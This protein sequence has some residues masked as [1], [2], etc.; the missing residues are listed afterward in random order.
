MV[1]KREI[2]DV[3][4]NAGVLDPATSSRLPYQPWA[5]HQNAT[6]LA[7]FLVTADRMKKGPFKYGQ[8]D[9]VF[10][11]ID[12]NAYAPVKQV[13]CV[14]WGSTATDLRDCL[15]LVNSFMG[16]YLEKIL[17]VCLERNEQS[18][19]HLGGIASVPGGLPPFHSGNPHPQWP[20]HLPNLTHDP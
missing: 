11:F 9:K 10:K 1:T 18:G 17:V 12:R 3:I 20:T 2:K 14:R 8:F 13:R 19:W 16:N 5:N 4:D 7:A 15:V 6:H